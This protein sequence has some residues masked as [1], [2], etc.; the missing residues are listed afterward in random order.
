MAEQPQ[1]QRD[2]NEDDEIDL[3]DLVARLWAGK[4]IIAAFVFVGFLVG[5]FQALNTPP[6]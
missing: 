5:Q 3:M 4:F 6:S 1:N 2:A